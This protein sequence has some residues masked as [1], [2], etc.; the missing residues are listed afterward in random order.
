MAKKLVKTKLARSKTR[1]LFLLVTSS[2]SFA[3]F[4]AS[5]QVP[6]FLLMLKTKK[7]KNTSKETQQEATNELRHRRTSFLFPP[8]TLFAP[9]ATGLLSY[10]VPYSIYYRP[11]NLFTTCQ[12]HYFPITLP[13]TLFFFFTTYLLFTISDSDDEQGFFFFVNF[14]MMYI[15]EVA[16]IHTTI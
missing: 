8:T 13:N 2:H 4:S 12:S 5:L 14:V 11:T 1:S 16:I 3:C 10:L 15:A 7:P 6:Q 9:F